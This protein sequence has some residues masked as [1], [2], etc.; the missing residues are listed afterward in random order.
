M[1]ND[2]FSVSLLS[3]FPHLLL[4]SFSL[5]MCP[6]MYLYAFVKHFLLLPTFC[7]FLTSFRY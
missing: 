5:C 6:F 4:L 2:E 1:N 3:T 7:R